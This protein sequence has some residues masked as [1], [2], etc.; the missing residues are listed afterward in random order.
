ML[1]Q[2][3]YDYVRLLGQPLFLLDLLFFYLMEIIILVIFLVLSAIV[4]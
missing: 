2:V 1:N 4:K 3:Q